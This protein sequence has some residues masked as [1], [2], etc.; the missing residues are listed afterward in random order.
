MAKERKYPDI[1]VY[2]VT[3]NDGDVVI[4]RSLATW[5]GFNSYRVG[6]GSTW[7]PEAV[8]AASDLRNVLEKALRMERDTQRHSAE[9]DARLDEDR[10]ALVLL[11][12]KA[13]PADRV[14]PGRRRPLD[15]DDIMRP[16]KSESDKR[17]DA[18]IARGIATLEALLSAM[19]TPVETAP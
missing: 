2:T 1:W 8:T 10:R 12:A 7:T 5:A 19:A 13:D 4:D 3:V 15:W 16:G 18:N 9:V 6:R 11:F 14:V 17:D